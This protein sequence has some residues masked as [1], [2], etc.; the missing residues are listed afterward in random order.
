MPSKASGLDDDT[1]IVITADHAAQTGRP[2]RGVPS[3]ATVRTHSW[4][5]RLRRHSLRL[6]LVLRHRDRRR[7]SESYEDPSPAVAQLETT[8]GGN[9]AFSYQDGHVAVWLT[10]NSLVKKQQAADAVLDMPGVIASYHLNAAQDDYVLFGTNP[11]GR[12]EQSWFNSHAEDL[13]DTMAAPNGP[14]VVGVVTTN[15]TYGVVGDHGGHNRLIQ[16]IPMVF[17]GPGV[18]QKDSN[19][20]LR[21]V[22]VL[23][24]IL[25]AMGIDYDPAAFDGEAV[26]LPKPRG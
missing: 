26:K 7:R 11:M 19:R 2:F 16:N 23:P 1:L 9:I 15:V 14:D 18:S 3:S 4:D 25:E 20:E 10:D 13:V 5:R 24:T 17:Y 21:Q 12:A 8:L 6:Q 22:D